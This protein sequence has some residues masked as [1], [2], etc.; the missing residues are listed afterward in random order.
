[1]AL[2][3]IEG[4][5]PLTGTIRVGTAKNAVLPIL[6]AALLVEQGTTEL[7]E[8][9]NLRDVATMEAVLESLG[10]RIERRGTT[11]RLDARAIHSTEPPAELVGL[12]RASVLVMGPLLARMGEVRVALPGGCNIGSRPIDQHLKGF[13]AL[14]AE[15]QLEQ[16]IVTARAS[17][18]LGTTI[19]FD[20]P[21]VGATE[22]VLM[23]ATLAHGETV[24]ENA[25]QEPEIVDLANFLNAMGARIRGAGTGTIRVEGVSRLS[26]TSYLPIPDRIEAG[27]YLVAFAFTGGEGY[28]EGAIA[29]HLVP[30]IAKLR[31]MGHYLEEDEDGIRIV[32]TRDPKPVDVKTQPYPGFPTDMQPQF[33]ALLATVPGTSVVTETVFENRFLHA[34]ELAKMGARIRIEGRTAVVEGTSL[35]GARVRATDLRAAAALVLAGLAARG[36]TEVLEIVHIERGYERLEEKLKGIGAKIERVEDK[37]LAPE[38]PPLFLP[39]FLAPG[40]T[41]GRGT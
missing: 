28:V 20:F 5:F 15:V 4:G 14:G 17:R 18:L 27:T 21:S 7:E 9:P 23:A 24:I 33:L 10:I 38:P 29:E 22:N 31:E 39:R 19:Y 37:D 36:T 3:R 34:A 1:M 12:M 16:G 11:H 6:A 40:E 35:V 8:I 32:A 26:G 13:Q 30:V 25:A 2:Y 41:V